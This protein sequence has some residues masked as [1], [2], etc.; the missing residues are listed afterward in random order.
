VGT[1][2]EIPGQAQDRVS[3]WGEHHEPPFRHHRPGRAAPRG[4]A[5]RRSTRA[6]PPQPLRPAALDA[7]A[8]VAGP[9]FV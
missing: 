6:G 5:A 4:A 2:V 7:D 3:R 9:P 8:A 1:D